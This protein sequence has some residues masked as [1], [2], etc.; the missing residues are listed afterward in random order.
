MIFNRK[1]IFKDRDKKNVTE[2][3]EI[4]KEDWIQVG[5]DLYDALG[6]KNPNLEISDKEKEE[7]EALQ[8]LKDMA[9]KNDWRI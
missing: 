1:Y 6:I 4:L 9:G 5:Q 3:V 8:A 2:D 7:D